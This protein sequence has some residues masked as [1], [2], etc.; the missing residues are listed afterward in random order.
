MLNLYVKDDS[1]GEEVSRIYYVGFKGDTKTF[2]QA[3]TS[4]LEIPAANAADAPLTGK[5][6]ERAA[7]QQSTAR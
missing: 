2:K 7:S 6:T 5:M 4:K 1:V 3:A